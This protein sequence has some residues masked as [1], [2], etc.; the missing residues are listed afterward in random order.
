M[1]MLRK[2]GLTIGA[3][4]TLASVPAP[5]MAQPMNDEDA[6]AMM[7]MMA[8]MFEV[9]PL[10]AE[11]EARLPIAR[12]VVARLIPE[13]AMAEMMDAMM[14]GVLGPMMDMDTAPNAAKVAEQL[15][16][17]A[18][19]L[20]MD[21]AA[22]EE[23]LTLL[24]PAWRERV[25]IEREMFPAM[26]SEM[27]TTMEPVMKKAMTELYA[28]HFT[29]S[30]L[31]DINAFFKT[32]TGASYARKSFT[33]ASD[34]RLMATTMEAL[35]DMMGMFETLDTRMEA[36]MADL[37]ET[38]DYDELDAAEKAR[39]A[40]LIGLSEAELEAQ[41]MEA[42]AMVDMEAIDDTMEEI[43]EEM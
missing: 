34:P 33:L 9:E 18:T 30:E 1:T 26:M 40:Q 23:A 20:T 5:A 22:A 8:G 14:G 3:A 38:R 19:E 17:Y 6:M 11:Q 15:G 28:V 13:G 2:M 16:L 27:M 43:A 36:A 32:E 25:A 37:P 4:V 31:T 10:T 41:R 35:P 7:A 21:D 12:E 39:L 24:D 42:D 29:G